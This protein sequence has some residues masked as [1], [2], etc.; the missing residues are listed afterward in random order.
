[1]K[2]IRRAQNMLEVSLLLAAI[3]AA[4]VMMQIYVKRSMMGRLRAYSERIGPKYAIGSTSS[5]TTNTQNLQ[6]S[7]TTSSGLTTTNTTDTK[8]RTTSE[9]VVAP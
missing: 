6:I 7:E 5:S 2:N 3:V 8:F 9:T 4:L 1:M